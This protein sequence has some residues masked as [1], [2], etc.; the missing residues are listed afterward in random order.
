[1]SITGNNISIQGMHSDYSRYALTQYNAIQY[2]LPKAIEKL[3]EPLEVDVDTS[4]IHIIDLGAAD[5]VNSFPIIE[6][7]AKTLIA[8]HKEFQPKLYVTHVDVPTAD[9]KSLSDNI[10]NHPDSYYSGL[11]TVLDVQPNIEPNSFYDAYSEQQSADIVFATTC[12]HYASKNAGPVDNHVD[13][14]YSKGDQHRVWSALSRSDLDLVMNQAHR[15]LRKGGKFWAIAPAHTRD[16]ID[17]S[18]KN[19]WNREVW[20]IMIEQLITMERS[21][22]VDPTLWQDFVIPVHQ[23]K[24]DEWCDWFAENTDKFNLEFAE[25]VESPNPYL[26]IFLEGHKSAEQ[27]ADDYLGFFKSWAD[28][29]VGSLIPEEEHRLVFYKNMRIEF[30]NNPERF[31]DDNVSVYVG[32]TAI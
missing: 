23:R 5:G 12:L 9:F 31:A 25:V 32:A 2:G 7:F 19:H 24:L 14:L 13:P 15:A 21:G 8:S 1:M 27:F 3:I 18:I 11:E 26:Q 30:Q 16:E 17:G 22:V 6:S 10:Y 28:R 29:I 20:N 4:G